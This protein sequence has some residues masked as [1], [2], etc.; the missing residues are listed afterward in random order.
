[1]RMINVTPRPCRSGRDS[2]RDSAAG[3][4]EPTHEIQ[5]AFDTNKKISSLVRL[6]RAAAT[7]PSI[8]P[9]RRPRT[10]PP[11]RRP[12]V[13]R[14][15][16]CAC[17]VFISSL[18]TSQTAVFVGPAGSSLL[19]IDFGMRGSKK[20]TYQNTARTARAVIHPR[21]PFCK[22]KRPPATRSSNS[23]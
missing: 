9:E 12:G 7:L 13:R 1:M 15:L 16:Q 22:K 19:T 5:T 4:M 21:H 14:R 2:K 23:P 11:C 17:P 20:T 18:T 8:S 6:G 3:G 10:Q